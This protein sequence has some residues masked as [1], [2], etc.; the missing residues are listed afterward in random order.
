[1]PTN[2]KWFPEQAFTPEETLR[3]YTIW[4]AYASKQENFTGTIE[5]GKWADLTFMD[6]DI[7][8]VGETNPNQILDGNI[9]K[10]IVNGEVVYEK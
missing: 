8:N 10:T 4:A 6:I 1:M 3:A 9:L 2:I 7:L 5:K